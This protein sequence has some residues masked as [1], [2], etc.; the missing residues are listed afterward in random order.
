MA[1][2]ALEAA[3]EEGLRVP[4]D[5]SIIGLDDVMVG[6]HISPSLTTIAIPKHRLAKEATKLLLRQIDGKSDPLESILL[7]PSL[8]I[9]R[10]TATVSSANAGFASSS[11]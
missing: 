3:R 11:G 7:P 10:S 1:I 9:R 4:E 2:G 8:L 6:A 5:L